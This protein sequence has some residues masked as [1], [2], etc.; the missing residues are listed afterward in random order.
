MI[1]PVRS[2]ALM[3]VLC[4]LAGSAVLAEE[5]DCYK[6]S[7]TVSD[8]VTNSPDKVL[9]IVQREVAASNDCACE[10]VK[11]AIVASEADRKLVGQIVS[12]AIE[13]APDKMRIIAQCAMRPA[14]R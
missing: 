7:V 13:A 11:A 4:L 2:T 9:Q 8:A 3:A 1:D 12:T 6:L 5:V 14:R 10:V